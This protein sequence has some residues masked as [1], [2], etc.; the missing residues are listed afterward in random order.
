MQFRN[1]PDYPYVGKHIANLTLAQIKTLDC[2]SKRQY[3]YRRY[4]VQSGLC[5]T[6]NCNYIVALQLTYPGTKISTLSELFQFAK[7]ADPKRTINWNVESK[8]NPVLADA[9]RSV[10]DFV[11]LQNM[12][13]VKSGYKLSQITVG[14]ARSVQ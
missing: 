1:D 8:I 10:E 3:A 4:H 14:H 2:G 12:E 9:T 11:T 7:C 6:I 5:L 13:F